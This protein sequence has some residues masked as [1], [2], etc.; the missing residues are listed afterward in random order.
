MLRA[1]VNQRTA[2]GG[3]GR[4]AGVTRDGGVKQHGVGLFYARDGIGIDAVL[5]KERRKAKHA[6]SVCSELH[7]CSPGN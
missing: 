7:S 5:A 1:G 6:G 2:L 3:N 4:S